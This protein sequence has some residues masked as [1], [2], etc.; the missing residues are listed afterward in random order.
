MSRLQWNNLFQDTL[1]TGYD[2]PACLVLGEQTEGTP[3][4]RYV[5]AEP[6]AP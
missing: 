5:R 4:K 6:Y 3:A 2:S 1:S